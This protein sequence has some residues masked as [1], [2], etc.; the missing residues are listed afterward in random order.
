MSKKL[1]NRIGKSGM[2][3]IRGMGLSLYH[4]KPRLRRNEPRM[5]NGPVKIIK[6]GAVVTDY[7]NEAAI[8]AIEQE[9]IKER[10][11]E[12]KGEDPA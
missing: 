4:G 3:P 6:K 9:Q 11:E 8:A 7:I 5:R 10:E 2:G 12:E 1:G